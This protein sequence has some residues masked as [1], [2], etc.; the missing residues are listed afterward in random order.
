MADEN[1][2]RVGR[3]RG[4]L[5]SAG[6]RR[7]L[8]AV[9]AAAL[10]AAAGPA[11]LLAGSGGEAGSGAKAAVG[12]TGTVE[13]RT[14]AEHLTAAG[15]IGYA[16]E[17]T[18]LA[19]LSGT[20][21]ALPAIGDVVRR[22]GRLYAVAG[23][24]V[25]LLYGSVP[26]YRALAEGV[27]EGA[28]VEQLERNLVALG[29]SPGSVDEVF[30][31]STAAAI[32]AW[33]EDLG[34]EA[35]GELELG[36][37]AFLRGPQRVTALEAILGEALGGGGGTGSSMV[38]WRPEA[39]GLGEAAEAAESKRSDSEP[40]KERSDPREEPE[41]E[42]EEGAEPEAAGEPKLEPEPS[43]VPVLRT[44]STRRVVSV[45]LEADQQSIAH[46]GQRVV[47]V[48]PDGAEVPGEVRGL[49]AVESLGGEGGPG[50]EAAPGVEA[51]ISVT[52]K[53]PIP[54]LDG[55]TVSVLF[56]Q[57]VG[58]DV[59]SVPLTALIAIGGDRFAVRVREPGGRRQIVVTP[60]LAAD[61]FVAVEGKGLR[62]GMT[63][64]TGE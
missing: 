6:R 23:E 3:L 27:S 37:V 17:T 19:R 59:L 63:V 14:L 50:E 52:G 10:L 57:R 51:T 36:R 64:E 53:R 8:L 22:G 26:A 20:V 48:L 56:T 58:H 7:P 55:A 42:R 61:G 2:E 15:T 40:R 44:S 16:G 29:Y 32:A 60:G 24:P 38:A 25:L 28:D 43:S 45:E 46:R 4:R 34:L 13:R 9:V 33:Q 11:L 49:A 1:R 54:A 41:P 21:T 62:A 18:V 39:E 5:V 12:A 30:S 35:T 31:S 47:V